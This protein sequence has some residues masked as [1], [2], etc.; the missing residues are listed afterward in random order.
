L[1]EGDIVFQ[2]QCVRLSSLP[3]A[4]VFEVCFDRQ[5]GPINKFDELTVEEL[6]Q[7]TNLLRAQPGLR[8]VLATSAK[9]VFIVG[10]DITEFGK[11]FAKTAEEIAADVLRSNEVFLAFEDLPV[12]TVVAINGFALGGG[13]EFA[14]ANAIRVMSEA[15]QVGVPEVKLGLFPGFGGT[16]RLLRIAGPTVAC[17]WVATGKPAKAK[18]ALDAGVVD[19]VAPAGALRE[20]AL[21]WLRRAIAGEV[22]WQAR[23]ARKRGALALPASDAAAAFQAAR[24]RAVQAS[25]PHQPAAVAAIDMMQQGAGGNRE[26]ALRLEGRVFGEVARTQAGRAMVQTFLN[27]QSVKK[28]ARNAAKGGAPVQRAAVLGAGIMGGGIAFASALKGVPVRM[29]DIRQ[30]ALDQGI[31]EAGKQLARQLKSGR[32]S[33]T[34]GAEVLASITPQ[35]DNAGVGEADLVIEAIVENLAVKQKVLGE[36]EP[37]LAPSAVLASNTS[38]LR[39]D[40]I[41]V[42]LR[43]PERLVG[44]HFFNPVPVMPLVEVVRGSSTSDAAVATA[45]AFAGM[46]GKTAI[47][48]R[49]CPG[50]LVNRVLTAYM[51]G[52]LQLVADGADFVKVDQAMEAFGWPMGPAYLEDVV[53]I[54][55]GSHVNDVISAGYPQR[56]PR[57][58]DDALRLLARM[59]RYGQKSGVGFYRY[60]P[61]SGGKPV[62]SVAGDTHALLTPLQTTGRREFSA[63]EIV[64]RMMLPMVLEAAHALHDGVVATP[65]EVDLAMQLGLGFPA[66]AGGPLK[67]ADWLGLG[68]VLARCDRLGH[69]G[70]AYEPGERLRDMAAKGTRFY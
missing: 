32:L 3:E 65:A 62:R 19:D 55:T 22:D 12:P 17:D 45:V 49:D 51:R 50:F 1:P 43:A 42:A 59:G 8:G 41:A 18:A 60:E 34:R 64:D 14:L 11:K 6:R 31:A 23:Q 53:G 26:E 68:D 5:G 44:M 33:E 37:F 70:V 52:F 29:K 36:L 9:D 24:A 57:F 54:D 35:L 46:M 38:S 58:E 16:V 63:E 10:A 67:Y 27:E 30:E 28:I 15:A 56:M 48:V 20:R 13:L 7:V 2:G 25:A 61:G 4:G 40:D 69:L 21:E 47:V 39:I 66:Y